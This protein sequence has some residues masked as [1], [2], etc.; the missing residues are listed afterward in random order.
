M[1]RTIYL[2]VGALDP[3]YLVIDR[4]LNRLIFIL[5]DAK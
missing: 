2:K 1:L 3:C 5:D 4:I